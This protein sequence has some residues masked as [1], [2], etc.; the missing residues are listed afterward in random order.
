M[1]FVDSN[2]LSDFYNILKSILIKKLKGKN[3]IVMIRR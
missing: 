1:I 2:R 3:R